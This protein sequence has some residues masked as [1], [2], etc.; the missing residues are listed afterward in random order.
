MFTPSQWHSTL[1]ASSTAAREEQQGGSIPLALVGIMKSSPSPLTALDALSV[2]IGG[3]Q[4]ESVVLDLIS[5]HS[6]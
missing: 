6:A 1:T 5:S 2:G 4:L 3:A